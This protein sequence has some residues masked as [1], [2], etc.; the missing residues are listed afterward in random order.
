[1]LGIAGSLVTISGCSE[2]VLLAPPDTSN[3]TRVDAVIEVHGQ[4]PDNP[5][6]IDFGEVNAGDSS[7]QLVTIK[8][9]GTD[10]LQVQDLVLSNFQS[11]E[12]VD[13]DNVAP[14]LTPEQQTE[15]TLRYSPVQDEHIEATL[16]VASNDRETP[17]VNVRLLAEGLAPTIRIDPESFDFGN[18]ELG[19]LQRRSRPADPVEHLV[20]GPREQR[21]DDPHPQ[22]PAGRRPRADRYDDPRGPLRAGR[23]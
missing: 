4:D 13:R 22:H 10:T 9:I 23:C 7:E 18:M 5:H 11:F 20:R 14:L 21:R 19:C 2:S 3:P 8:N 17:E 16:I 1:M 6:V 12:I 15:L